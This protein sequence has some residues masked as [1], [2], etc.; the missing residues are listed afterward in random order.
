MNEKLKEKLFNI[1]VDI[2]AYSII[3]YI[4]ISWFF[5]ILLFSYEIYEVFVVPMSNNLLFSGLTIP[6]NLFVQQY[7][8]IP[9]D[10]F[11]ES[12]LI[13]IV[14]STIVFGI[15]YFKTKKENHDE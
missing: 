15:L 14:P 5:A 12:E 9:I 6:H 3:G 8:P 7:A 10:Q 2:F 11:I 4:L 1:F 13:L